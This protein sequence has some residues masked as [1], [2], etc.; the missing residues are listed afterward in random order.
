MVL[1]LLAA[2]L[3]LVAIESCYRLGLSISWFFDR[4]RL[5]DR[6][7]ASCDKM[8]LWITELFTKK[9]KFSLK[10]QPKDFK[11]KGHKSKSEKDLEDLL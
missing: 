2:T 3:T 8:D 1:C 4:T 5:I 6:T 7:I 10:V 9:P 11:I